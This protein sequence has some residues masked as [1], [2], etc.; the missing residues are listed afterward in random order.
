MVNTHVVFKVTIYT[1]QIVSLEICSQKPL[2]WRHNGRDGVSNPQPFGCL[3]NRLFRR[4]LKKASMLR[5]TGLCEGNSSVIG[6]F[7]AQRA[8]NTENVSIWWRHRDIFLIV[9]IDLENLLNVTSNPAHLKQPLHRSQRTRMRSFD[10]F[11]ISCWTNSR[12]SCDLRRYCTQSNECVQSW[13]HMKRI[14]VWSLECCF[15]S[16][17]DEFTNRRQVNIWANA[18]PILWRAYVTYSLYCEHAELSVP[19]P[20][21]RRVAG[22]NWSDYRSVDIFNIVSN[23]LQLWEVHTKFCNRTSV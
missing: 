10:I 11:S 16:I 12:I 2:Q 18:D 21:K 20:G 3:L 22:S 9:K 5:V 23:L 17:K 19:L 13:S 14:I 8:S 15:R 4:K 6:E 1:W 7:P